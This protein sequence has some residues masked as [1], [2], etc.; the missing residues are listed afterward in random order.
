ME[1]F[2]PAGQRVSMDCQKDFTFRK[3]SISEFHRCYATE[4]NIAVH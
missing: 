4:T 1:M 3:P 2:I